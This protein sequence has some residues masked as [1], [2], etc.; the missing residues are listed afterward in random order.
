[1]RVMM[2]I[3]G[4]VANMADD[5]MQFALTNSRKHKMTIFVCSCALG[6]TFNHN[7][8]KRNGFVRV[9]VQHFAFDLLRTRFLTPHDCGINK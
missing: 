6:C 2:V 4:F 8:G 9:Q 3:Q 5:Q 1:M 7:G